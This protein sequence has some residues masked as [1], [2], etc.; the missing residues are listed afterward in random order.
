MVEV[1]ANVE[2]CIEVYTHGVS[3]PKPKTLLDLSSPSPSLPVA[4]SGVRS[5]EPGGSK[6]VKSRIAQGPQRFL[7]SASEA[8]RSVGQRSG[9]AIPVG[10][11]QVTVRGPI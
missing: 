5:K 11:L 4:P 6:Q 2:D 8:R 3:G 7:G 9:E 1:G 10:Y